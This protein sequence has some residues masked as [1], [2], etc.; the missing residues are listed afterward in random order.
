MPGQL[1]LIPNLPEAKT[2]L[3]TERKIH[4]NFHPISFCY[5]STA[6]LHLETRNQ[7]GTL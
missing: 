1:C 2:L 3:Q 7:I 4:N 6:I 5:K